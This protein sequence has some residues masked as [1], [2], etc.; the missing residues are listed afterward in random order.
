M[1]TRNN[2]SDY[3]QFTSSPGEQFSVYHNIKYT[4]TK[5]PT[6]CLLQKEITKPIIIMLLITNAHRVAANKFPRT[7]IQTVYNQYPF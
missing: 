5:W 2:E 6:I 1:T 7:E 4:K 3:I